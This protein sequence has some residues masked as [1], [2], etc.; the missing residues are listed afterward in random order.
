M[1]LKRTG[2]RYRIKFFLQTIVL[3]ENKE[4]LLAFGFL[5]C[6]SD[7][8]IAFVIYNSQQLR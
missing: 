2:S 6:S 7:E 1:K 8:L 3:D 4:P 5:R